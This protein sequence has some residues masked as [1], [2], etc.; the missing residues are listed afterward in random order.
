MT[1]YKRIDISAIS[2]EKMPVAADKLLSGKPVQSAV[3]QYTNDKENF[4]VGVWECN[5]GKWAVD[6]SEEEFLTILEGE[7][8]ITEI[9]GEPQT[10][11]KGDHMVISKGFVGTWETV[12]YVKKLYVIYED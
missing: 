5:S 10:L 4:F 2:D 6:Y 8:I 9:G 1:K 11:K 7:A 12:D 3:N